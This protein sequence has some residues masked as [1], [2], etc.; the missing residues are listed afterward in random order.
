MSIRLYS[1]EWSNHDVN[2]WGLNGSM[3]N[4]LFGMFKVEIAVVI[5]LDMFEMDFCCQ[6]VVVASKCN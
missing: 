2:I 4:I 3:N 5:V 6:S 1:G